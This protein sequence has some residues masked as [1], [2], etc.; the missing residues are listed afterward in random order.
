MDKLS[1]RIKICDRMYPMKVRKEEEALIRESAKKINEKIAEYKTQFGTN[2]NQDLLAVVAFD[3]MLELTK[4]KKV[5]EKQTDDIK[6]NISKMGENI[7]KIL[8]I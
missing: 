2:D 5:F 7:S 1:I 4:T 3:F 8:Q 6:N